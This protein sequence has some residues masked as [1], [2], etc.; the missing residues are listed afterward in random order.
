MIKG[1][2]IPHASI[3]IPRDGSSQD[4][5]STLWMNNLFT[6]QNLAEASGHNSN[7]PGDVYM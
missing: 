6:T 4:N 2:E 1:F 5:A 7:Q 3:S